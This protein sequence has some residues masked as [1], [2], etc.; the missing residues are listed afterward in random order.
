MSNDNE[1]TV[2]DEIAKIVFS[3]FLDKLIPNLETTCSEM[4]RNKD[5]FDKVNTT[6]AGLAK[7][8]YAAADSMR[9]ARLGAFD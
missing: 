1:F 6:I 5:K 7:M 9:K 4:V 3:K 2:R 8:S